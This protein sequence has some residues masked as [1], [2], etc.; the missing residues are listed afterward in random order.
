MAPRSFAEAWRYDNHKIGQVGLA[1]S[2]PLF[3]HEAPAIT[4]HVV[5]YSLSKE[6]ILAQASLVCRFNG[7]WPRLTDLQVRITYN[8]EPLIEKGMNI[9]PLTR[10]FFVVVF[11][12][13]KD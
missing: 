12:S 9:S 8:W 11:E 13:P 10:W 1:P 3:V 5:K 6:K 4:L 7:I 2:L